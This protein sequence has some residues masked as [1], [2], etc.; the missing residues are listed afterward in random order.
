MTEI[1]KLELKKEI[2]STI[3]DALENNQPWEIRDYFNHEYV[4][5]E[6]E[7]DHLETEEMYHEGL[8]GHD[9]F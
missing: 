6:N 5:L 4:R 9:S 3:I 7:I 2:F 8:G 1:E